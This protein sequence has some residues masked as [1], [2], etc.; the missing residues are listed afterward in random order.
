MVKAPSWL[1]RGVTANQVYS[2]KKSAGSQTLFCNRVGD[3]VLQDLQEHDLKRKD[4]CFVEG[5]AMEI[6]KFI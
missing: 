5:N 4:G 1:R 2:A 6:V 3:Q